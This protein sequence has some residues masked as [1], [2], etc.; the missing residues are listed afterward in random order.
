M[1]SESNAQEVVNDVFLSIW[2]KR[3]VLILDESLKAY[4]FQ[5]TK[6]RS[7]N[8]LKKNK[9]T[10][11][12]LDEDGDIPIAADAQQLL[13]EK[14]NEDRISILMD[15]LPPKCKQVFTMSRFDGLNNKDISELMDISVK[16]VENQMTKALK[17]FRKNLK[18]E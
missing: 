9:M 11:L 10:F 7:I 3:D 16:T 13:E 17:F 12:Q 14:D 15:Q 18:I 1:R 4:L 6:N 5:A 8:H 2:E